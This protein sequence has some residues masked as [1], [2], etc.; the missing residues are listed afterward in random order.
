MPRNRL[1]LAVGVGSQN[2]LVIGF[3]GF[4]DG[5]NVLFAV[6]RH[7]PGHGEIIFGIDRAIFGRQIAHMSVGGQNDII[8]SKVLV[9]GLGFGRGF[10]DDDWHE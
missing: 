5:A 3:Q 10:D 2:Q 7:F 8:R 4:G 9:D 1:S 6:G